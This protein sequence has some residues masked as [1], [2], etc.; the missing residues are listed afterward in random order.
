MSEL[1]KGL[2]LNSSAVS[3]LVSR[4]EKKGFLKRTFGSEDRRAV[5]V[6]LTKKGD[7]LRNQVRE[8]MDLLNRTITEGLSQK[9]IENLQDTVTILKKNSRK[10]TR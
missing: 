4:M 1:S 6:Q 8:K 9:D 7:K 2:D 3:T 10:K 5:F